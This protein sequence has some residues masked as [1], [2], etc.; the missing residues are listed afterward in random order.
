VDKP[1]VEKSFD[2]PVLVQRVFAVLIAV[3]WIASFIAEPSLHGAL[4]ILAVCPMA[5]LMAFSPKSFG[6]DRSKAWEDRHPILLS[7]FM[8]V[9]T[10][11]VTYLILSWFLADRLSIKIAIPVGL[12]YGVLLAVIPRRR[13]VG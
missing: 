2:P 9:Y 3:A 7:V 1:V 4:W 10:G 11:L 6:E 12:V 5:A 8:A 13:R